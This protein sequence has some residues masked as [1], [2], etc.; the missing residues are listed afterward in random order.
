MTFEG[1]ACVRLADEATA[2]IVTTSVGPRVLSLTGRSGNLMAVLPEGGLDRPDGGRFRFYGGHRLWAAP[3]VPDVTYQPDDRPCA[4]TEVQ[5]GVRVEAPGDGAGLAK[6]IEIRRTAD[7]WTVDHVI[8][9]GSKGPVAIAPWA[10]SQLRPGG[11]AILPAE[12]RGSGPQA[13]RSLVLWSYTD[14]AD[15]RIAFERGAIRIRSGPAGPALK[16]GLA[17]SD[18]TV[19]Y[20]VDGEVFEKRI[21]VDSNAVYADLGAAVQVYVCEDFCELETLGPLRTLRPG[22]QT[23]HRERWSLRPDGS[24]GGEAR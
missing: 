7:G 16:L 13:D 14:L 3:E 5:G 9:N 21:D 19:A 2:V 22:E 17:P 15:S 1:H 10:V 11:E 4:V 12:P 24:D 18:G 6:A 20:R 8:R 23:T